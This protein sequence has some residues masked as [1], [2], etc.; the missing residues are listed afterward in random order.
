MSARAVQLA[1]RRRSRAYFSL[2]FGVA[3]APDKSRAYISASGSNE[4]AILDLRKLVA[5][6]KS[7]EAANFANDLSAS[8]QYVIARIP[9]GR[10]PRSVVLS[11]DGARLYVANRLDDT[12]SVI[13]TA[14]AASH[15][16]DSARRPRR[17]HRRTPRR[18]PVLFLAVRLRNGQFGCANCHLDSTF[19]G[20]QWDLEPDGFGIDIVDNRPLEDIGDTAP[21]KWNGGNPDLETECGPRTERF[22]FRSQG[23]RGEDLQD[24]VQL[25]QVDSAAPQPLPASRWR[26]DAGAGARQSHLRADQRKKD[27][28]PIP[29]AE[30]VLRL[31]LRPVLHQPATG[32]CGHG[33][34]DR[35]F[36]RRSMFRN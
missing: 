30:P 3:I 5:A 15:R 26:A 16:H 18:T 20:L 32:R 12:I 11:P 4:V 35:P 9:V 33:Q 23:F 6:A 13:D 29:G 25:H 28:T 36:A 17:A 8:A 22:F 34:A 19:D 24:L 7:P 10:N 27:G 1:A 21:F 14:R 2:P 31:P